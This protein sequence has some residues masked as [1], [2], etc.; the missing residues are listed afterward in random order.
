MEKSRYTVETL[1]RKEDRSY[2]EFSMFRVKGEMKRI[3]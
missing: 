3:L 2:K 1:G